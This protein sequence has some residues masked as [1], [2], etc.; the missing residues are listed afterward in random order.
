MEFRNTSSWERGLRLGLG[1]LMLVLGWQPWI[2]N[3]AFVFRVVAL[4]PLITGLVGWCPVYAM[5]R[6]GTRRH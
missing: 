3:W 6:I 5:L 1:L 4:F 2:G